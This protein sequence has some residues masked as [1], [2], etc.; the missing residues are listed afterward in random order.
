MGVKSAQTALNKE[1]VYNF[2]K[3]N[4][5][6]NL[7]AIR[8][9]FG[10]SK[11][12]ADYYVRPMV[13]TGVLNKHDAV[14]TKGRM[15]TLTIGRKSFVR[16]VKTDDEIFDEQVQKQIAEMPVEIQGA[17]RFVKLSNRNMQPPRRKITTSNRSAWTG[18]SMSM[19]DSL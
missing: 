3:A 10:F 7:L 11:S 1:N 6:T 13:Y 5:H 4:P 16:T 15:Y 12:Q 14:S 2:I 9:H 8:K 18:S 17:A 19:F